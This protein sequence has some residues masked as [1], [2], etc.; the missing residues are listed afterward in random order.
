MRPLRVLLVAND[1]LS[2]GHLVR[3]IAVARALS[4]RGPQ[5]G[6]A[7]QLLLATTSE[8]DALLVAEPITVV[9]L[10][11]PLAARRAGL[12]D[13]DRRRIVRGALEGIAQAFAPD[14]LVVDTFPSGPHGET[15][16][17]CVGTAKRVLLRRSVPRERAG[18]PLL[19]DGLA[20][21][22]LAI[23]AADP[24]AEEGLTMP[25]PFVGVPPI[26]IG[27][28]E[29]AKA[30]AEARAL[31]G[32]PPDGRVVLITSGGGGDPEARQ[33]ATTIA[34]AI[35]R[36]APD[37]IAVHAHGPLA[38]RGDTAPSPTMPRI[39]GIRSI[40]AAPLQPLLAAFDGAFSAA[41]YN[42]AHE[43]AKAGVPAAL[44]AEPRPFDDQAARAA[45][46]AAA[47]LAVEL[48]D[49]D[50]ATVASALAW[51]RAPPRAAR[52]EAEGAD[53]AADALLD[54]AARGVA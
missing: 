3:T 48:R 27:E 13:R 12:S 1:G 29:G 26:T 15:A 43:L 39:G 4:R 35:R 38:P 28:A 49:F 44:F 52:V 37:V 2:A 42:T 34:G 47:S 31:L 41:G 32:L 22:D 14:L 46:F 9:R 53:R 30:R 5:R 20:D 11:A 17:L 33:H 51:M 50:D 6:I 25:I 21:Y 19:M 23:V 8:A 36:V 10:P 54:H 16:G 45:R 24:F 7:V 40:H 18:D